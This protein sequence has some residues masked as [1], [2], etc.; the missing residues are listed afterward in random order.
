[1]LLDDKYKWSMS[2]AF[3]EQLKKKEVNEVLNYNIKENVRVPSI[4]DTNLLH[5]N[6]NGAEE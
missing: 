6:K 5:S 2:D 3:T 1:M 4:D